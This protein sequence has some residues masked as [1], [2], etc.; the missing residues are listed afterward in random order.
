MMK[1]REGA[2]RQVGQTLR[3]TCPGKAVPAFLS[4]WIFFLCLRHGWFYSIHACRVLVKVKLSEGECF[5]LFFFVVN[6]SGVGER[7]GKRRWTQKER[8]MVSALLCVCQG[9]NNEEMV[10][11]FFLYFFSSQVLLLFIL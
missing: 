3:E 2:S 11:A 4:F 10:V 8:V 7:D 6:K 9:R 1:T 5:H